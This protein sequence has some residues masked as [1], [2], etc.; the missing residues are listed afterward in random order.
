MRQDF[1]TYTPTFKLLIIGNHKPALN[2][3]DVAIRRRFRLIPFVHRPRN[4]DPHLQEKLRAE[5]PAILRWMI[6]GCLDWQRNGLVVPASVASAT[7]DYP[8]DQD[9]FA[10]WLDEC[11]DVDVNNEHKWASAKAL[12]ASWHDHATAGGEDPDTMKYSATRWSAA[13]L[14]AARKNGARSAPS[15]GC[16]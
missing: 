2:N 16:G 9:S 11:Y 12:F 13:A 3:V 1:F 10:H 5:W 6:D 7:D 8:A 4:P 15:R 14:S